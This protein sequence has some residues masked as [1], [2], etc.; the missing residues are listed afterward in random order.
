MSDALLLVDIQNDFMPDGSLPVPEGDAVVP[1]ANA[2]QKK[3]SV[4]VASQDWHPPGHASFA[5]EHAGHEPFEVI[6]F[7]GLEQVLW[8]DHCLQNSVGAEFHPDLDLRGVTH[9]LRKGIDPR[10][11]SYSAF[12]DNGHR[13]STGLDALLRGLDVD[14]VYIAGLAQDVCVYFTAMDAVE[15]G[16]R[17]CLVEDGTRGV[18]AQEGD[19]GKVNRKMREAGVEF[20]SSESVL[21]N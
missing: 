18:D 14:T 4:V 16:F 9:I 6:E 21:A 8:P 12:F 20:I 11:D 1:V 5:S 15:C 7:D 3:F 13:R 19:V 17:T 10:I 2:L